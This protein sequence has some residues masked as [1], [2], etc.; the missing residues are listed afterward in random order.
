MSFEA[1]T[2]PVGGDGKWKGE[3]VQGWDIFGI[4]NG[5]YVMAMTTRAMEVE[6]GGR[7]LISASGSYVNPATPGHVDLDVQ[8]LKEGRSLSTLRTTVSRDGTD[9][10]YFTGVY[11][12]AGRPKHE[13][14]VILASP[15]ELPEP[16]ACVLAVP[17]D[18]APIPPPFTGMVEMRA[19]PED[20]ETIGVG[21]SGPLRSR[22]WFRLKGDE[23]LD[24]HAVVLATDAFPPTIFFS[25][26]G[27][28]WTP[29]VEL[30]VQVRDPHPTGWLACQFTT[31]FVT[32]GLLEEDGEL[33]DQS[34]N[35]V[36]LSRQ[37]ALVPR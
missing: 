22:G 28:G 10:A 14:D 37:L 33:W 1:A 16:D 17:A 24:A 13:G 19:A 35:L 31:R 15:P 23:S 6:S 34:G 20:L 12:D 18:D 27:V 11:E 36:A 26:L 29:T 21:G 5:G 30:T 7:T 9:L 3:L 4:T 25:D 2:R 32:D 8:V